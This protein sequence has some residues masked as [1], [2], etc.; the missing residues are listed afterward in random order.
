MKPKPFSALNHF[1]VPSDTEF[2]FSFALPRQ[3]PADRRCRNSTPMVFLGCA[4]GRCHVIRRSTAR[5]TRLA[6]PSTLARPNRPLGTLPRAAVGMGAWSFDAAEAAPPARDEHRLV[7]T[8]DGTHRSSVRSSRPRR[9]RERSGRE[10]AGWVP[11]LYVKPGLSCWGRAVAAVGGVE[12][13]VGT[14]G[15]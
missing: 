11:L 8:V 9:P 4:S 13:Q 5:E 10:R 12:V 1:T 6:T 7:S 14:Q 3:G 2:L 15:R